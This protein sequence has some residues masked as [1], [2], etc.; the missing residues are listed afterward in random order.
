MSSSDPGSTPSLGLVLVRIV[1]GLVL[2]AAGWDAW[3]GGVS[4]QIV[5]RT[6]PRWAEAPEYVRAWGEQFV[7]KHPLAI[8]NVVVWGQV[9]FGVLLFLGAFTRPVGIAAA[10]LFANAIFAAQSQHQPYALLLC[11]S[12]L[13]CALSGAGRSIGADVFLNERL[14][15][16]LTWSRA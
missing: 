8:A 10:F 14:P 6:A 3:Q 11:A 9:V 13:G 15:G 12:C 4:A 2:L 1:T 16:W 5:E 7:L